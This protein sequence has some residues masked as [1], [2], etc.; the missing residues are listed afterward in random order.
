M[1]GDNVMFDAL[2]SELAPQYMPR[3][4]TVCCINLAAASRY[5]HCR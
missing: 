2:R 4:Y 5:K 3:N 1:S